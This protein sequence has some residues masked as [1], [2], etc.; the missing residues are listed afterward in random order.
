MRKPL[1]LRVIA[2][3]LLGGMLLGGC[4]PVSDLPDD[5]ETSGTDTSAPVEEMKL[6]IFVDGS[7]GNPYE[8]AGLVTDPDQAY[9][10]NAAA[11]GLWS[12]PKENSILITALPE[13]MGEYAIIEMDVFLN[14]VLPNG[15]RVYI[16]CGTDENGEETY[17]YKDVPTENDNWT[18]VSCV[19]NEMFSHGAADITKAEKIEIRVNPMEKGLKQLYVR[20][21]SA[22][23]Y[24]PGEA[25]KQYEG[26]TDVYDFILKQCEELEF[27]G[28][29]ADNAVLRSMMS[30]INTNCKTWWDRI[31]RKTKNPFGFGSNYPISGDAMNDMYLY[32]EYMARGYATPGSD[33]YKNEQLRDDIVYCLDYMYDNYYGGTESKMPA[34]TNW[35]DSYVES[36]LRLT[37]ALLAIRDTL[38][39][40]EIDRYTDWM[41]SLTNTTA[42]TNAVSSN[43]INQTRW[44]VLSAAMQKEGSRIRNAIDKLAADVFRITTEKN[45]VYADGSYIFH[46]SIPYTTGYGGDLLQAM[47]YV[48]YMV[49]GTEYS[50]SDEQINM[51][52]DWIFDVFAPVM[53]R[54]AAM[55]AVSGRMV[56][57]N[58]NETARATCVING[59][60][61]IA[62]YAPPERAGA[63][64]SLLKYYL[65]E[66]STRYENSLSLSTAGLIVALRND[67]SIQPAEPRV[68]ANV[69]N[70]MAR[71]TTF[72]GD[73]ASMLAMCSPTVARYEGFKFPTYTENVTGWY[74]GSGMLYVYADSVTQYDQAFHRYMNRYRLPGTTV[75]PRERNPENNGATYNQS[76]FVGGVQMDIYAAAGF[77]YDNKNGDFD[78]DLVAKKSYFFFDNEYVMLG[79]DITSTKDS[80]VITTVENQKLASSAIKMYLN[81][82]EEAVT[83]TKDTLVE[84]VKYA[85]ISQYGSIVFPEKQDLT[86]K[87]SNNSGNRFAE[88]FFDHGVNPTEDTYSYIILPLASREDGKAYY[89][90]PDVEILSNTK[91]IQAVR[92]NKLGLTGII[93]WGATEFQGITPDFACTMLVK[94]TENGKQIAVSDPTTKLSGQHTIVLDGVYTLDGAHDKITVTADGSKTTVTID[95]TGLDGQTV[96]FNLAKK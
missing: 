60:A 67:D 8:N 42:Y 37:L 52:V 53:W 66:N 19:L 26:A 51:Q 76:D 23:G 34:G 94:D 68:S 84:G 92:E 89:E 47:S 3:L 54:G 17:Y 31:N 80:G 38:E 44:I 21:I 48:V 79:A 57:S 15:M 81:D 96:L 39:Y 86:V 56:W 12:K 41:D 50:F 88:I 25:P 18:T 36:P 70:K 35:H 11:L 43:L 63:V 32:I 61:R 46:D 30:K 33:Y 2:G 16:Y 72:R 10:K 82:N 59:M 91:Q 27:G 83:A 5:T 90:N 93:F 49:A 7:E 78:S 1:F 14:N 9:D 28:Y 87:L 13:N 24:R 75:D 64:K 22:R 4:G 85:Y 55:S 58:P 29:S 65:T 73:Y 74:T 20:S 6:H 40:D 95:M 71:V 62:E 45:G 77:Q 69:F